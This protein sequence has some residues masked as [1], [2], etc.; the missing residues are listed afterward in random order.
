MIAA[1]AGARMQGPYR[2]VMLKKSEGGLQLVWKTTEEDAAADLRSFVKKV[3]PAVSPQSNGSAPAAVLGLDGGGVAFYRIKVPPV[4]DDQLDSIV[5]MQA[6]SLLPL[7]ADQMQM[8]WRA[9]DAVDGKRSCSIA[10]ARSDQLR[11]FVSDA[12][13]SVS[14][15]LLD[16]EAV[17]KAWMELFDGT[18]E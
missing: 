6:E 5:R 7:P 11:R 17:V 15:I 3:M 13:D 4:D 8:V 12:G 10:A 2:A 18:I 16:A 9:A 14:Q 1:T